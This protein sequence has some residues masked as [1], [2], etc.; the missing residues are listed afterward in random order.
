MMRKIGRSEKISFPEL[1]IE[2]VESK[3]DTGAFGTSLH[4]DGI[5]IKDEKLHFWIGHKNNRFVYSNYKVIKVRSSFGRIQERYSIKTTMYLGKR[6]YKV[7][8]SLT[9]RKK[10]KFPCLVGRR[11]LYKF[12]YIVDVRKKNI[13]DKS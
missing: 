3:I 10:M 2:N 7:H 5:S 8:I 13:Y 4:V 9:N 12:G 1:G 11:F 6:K